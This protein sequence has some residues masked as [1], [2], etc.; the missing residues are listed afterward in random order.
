MVA[1][2]SP[3]SEML[4]PLCQDISVDMVAT[5]CMWSPTRLHGAEYLAVSGDGLQLFKRNSNGKTSWQFDRLPKFTSVHFI[6]FHL[7][8]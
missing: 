4:K 2:E 7:M 3:N 5:K 8:W 1:L 6:L